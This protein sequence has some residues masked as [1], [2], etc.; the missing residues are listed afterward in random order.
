M[1]SDEGKILKSIVNSVLREVKKMPVNGVKYPVAMDEIVQN[2]ESDFLQSRENEKTVQ[3]VGIVGI[4]GAGKTILAME[5]YKRKSS[6]IIRSSFLSDVRDAAAKNAIH[7]KQKK[8][9]EDLR[10]QNESFDNIEEGKVILANR[11]RSLCVLIVLDDVDHQDQLDALLPPKDS[12]GPG[13][14]IIVTTREGSILTNAGITS[15]HRIRTLHQSH[16]EKLFCYH[17]FSGPSPVEG[18]EDL[19]GR[20]LKVCS[21]LPLSLKVIGAQLYGIN[22]KDYW[23]SLLDKIQR[24][25]PKD[26]KDKLKVSYEA[27]DE[28]EQEM[29]LDVACFFIGEKKSLAI[30]VWDGSGLEW[31]VWLGNAFQQ[32]SC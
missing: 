6:S 21:G 28:E 13:S 18:F 30:A 17:A 20:F 7:T 4:G 10:F 12:L 2:F 3:I 11:L 24:K 27:L 1:F 8:L 26:I 25:L 32:V 14:L 16:A 29:F 9:L 15:V 31:S 19:V 22:S 5:L 23:E